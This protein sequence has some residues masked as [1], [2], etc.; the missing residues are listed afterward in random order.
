[1]K[2]MI[3][4]VVLSAALFCSGCT[5]PGQAYV[6]QHPELSPQQ[7]KIFLTKKIVDPNAVAGVT[8]DQ[9]HLAMGEPSQ[10]A[11]IEGLDA[12]IYIRPKSSEY[13]HPFIGPGGSSV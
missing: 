11:K 10:Y 7:Q 9:I 2:L 6:K 12:W 5:T 3:L 8:R 13:I 1:M 4:P